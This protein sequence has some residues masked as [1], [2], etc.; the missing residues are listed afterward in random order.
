MVSSSYPESDQGVLQDESGWT[1]HKKTSQNA[2][3]LLQTLFE[4]KASKGL[5]TEIAT[6][7]YAK[8]SL[9][10]IYNLYDFSTDTE[11]KRLAGNF[12]NL[13]Y[14]DWALEQFNGFRGGSKHRAYKGVASM[15]FKECTGWIP[16]GLRDQA[17]HPGWMAAATTAWRPDPLVVELALTTEARGE[18]EIYSRRP[19][20]RTKGSEN[21]KACSPKGVSSQNCAIAPK[22]LK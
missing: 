15:T 17:L 19:G 3:W 21:D 22:P 4:E 16:F 9:N 8:Y 6:P 13:Y 12:L 14:A 18:Y 5:Y 20:L 1:S 2:R 10:V 7:T 11:L